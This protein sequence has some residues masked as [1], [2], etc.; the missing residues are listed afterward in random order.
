MPEALSG[1]ARFLAAFFYLPFGCRFA[2]R[3]LL[4]KRD[5]RRQGKH[6][7]CCRYEYHLRYSQLHNL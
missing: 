2:L 6:A 5:R 1:A 4:R 3:V 7:H